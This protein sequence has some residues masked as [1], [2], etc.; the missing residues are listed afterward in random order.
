MSEICIAK[1]LWGCVEASDPKNWSAML[2]RIK[3]DG[4]RAVESILIFDF[5]QDPFLFRQLLDKYQ[6]DLIIQL[7]TGS[8]WSKYDYCTSCDVDVHVASF[9]ALVQ[10]ALQHRPSV[11]NVHS[12]HDSWDT[13][14]GVSYFQR[15]F[16]IEQEL[17]V[18][19]FA[20]VILVHETHR[21]RLLHSPY[22]ARDILAHP[23]LAAL[24]INC[25]LSHWVC[26]CEKIFD[27]KEARDSWWPAV[28]AT[29]ARHCSLIHARVGH[30]EGPQVVDPRAPAASVELQAHLG[31]WRQLLQQQKQRG[32]KQVY[33]TTEHGPEPYQTF[34][35]PL[36]LLLV[37]DSLSP[38]AA[39]SGS[40]SAP[41]APSASAIAPA[42]ASPA[43]EGKDKDGRASDGGGA[44][45]G[46]S[47]GAG[48]KSAMTAAEKS[49]VL[50]LINDFVRREVQRLFTETKLE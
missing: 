6:L 29:A 9:R 21:Q 1:S 10:D 11:I 48:G 26:V 17:L 28:L 15:V 33:V 49:A 35:T 39:M 40:G 25:D 20:N 22:Q 2:A 8:D 38:P 31:W 37:S 13:A 32:M 30:A 24:K 27:E 46:A 14:T 12:G 34:D 42:A 23:S 45:G 4:Y 18:G 16:A 44:S 36:P 41:C 3:K 7:H 47:G 5:N 43:G 19:E 50:W